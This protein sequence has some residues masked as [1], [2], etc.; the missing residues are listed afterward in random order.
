[1]ALYV[2]RSSL[3]SLCHIC[4]VCENALLNSRSL[5]GGHTLLKVLEK[6]SIF[7]GPQRSLKTLSDLE[8]FEI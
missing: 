8:S 3:L 7:A 2:I 1:M 5:L 4:G 6:V